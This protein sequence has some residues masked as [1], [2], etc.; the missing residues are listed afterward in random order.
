MAGLPAPASLLAFSVSDPGATQIAS[1]TALGL[2]YTLS[3]DFQRALLIG[4]VGGFFQS[5]LIGASRGQS[6]LGADDGLKLVGS[7][8]AL[9]LA[10]LTARDA[11]RSD[12]H[13][14]TPTSG[15]AVTPSASP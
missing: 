15:S 6:I 13:A 12:A 1:S 9:A 10:G 8:G 2:G 11:V 7:L 14:R 5:S 3:G 4:L